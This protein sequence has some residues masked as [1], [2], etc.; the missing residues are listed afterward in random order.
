[1][2][3][4]A[5]ISLFSVRASLETAD[6]INVHWDTSAATRILD[7]LV[8]G[9]TMKTLLHCSLTVGQSRLGRAL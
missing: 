4:K 6:K 1:V 9:R 8:A 2:L 7:A 5:T 3:E